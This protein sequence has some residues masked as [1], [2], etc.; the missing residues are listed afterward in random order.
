MNHCIGIDVSKA[1][2]DA[3]SLTP[4]GK[5]RIKQFANDPSGWAKLLRWAKS[6]GAEPTHYCLEA[7][8]TLS[9]GI[10]LF[11]VE[12]AQLV[13]V[14]NPHR[15]KHFGIGAGFLNKTDRADARIIALYCQKHNPS[16]WRMSAP[17][18][19]ALVAML[20]RLDA[21]KTHLLQEQNRLS[22][23]GLTR[24]VL[25]SLKSSIRFLKKES[26][27]LEAQIRSHIDQHP[28]L[29]ADKELLLSI[30]GI[31][32][33]AAHWILA[34]LP[35]VTT[36]ESAQAAGAYAGLSPRVYQSGTSIRKQTQISRA[37]NARLR[38]ALYMPAMSAIRCNP[39]IKAFYE[40]LIAAG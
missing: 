40:R 33:M 8:G 2:L 25:R 31:G 23:P 28:K 24:E 16:P 18:V 21:L 5:A 13:S 37:G 11:L 34:E 30:P 3:C 20:R 10:A 9:E 35:D 22:E 17:E 38:T 7:T 36:L 19:R 1:T 32:E 29:K 4:N 15:I 12:A 39:L 26:D 27:R 6:L 14:E